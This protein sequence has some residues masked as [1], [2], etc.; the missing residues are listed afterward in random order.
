M[1]KML[2]LTIKHE[3]NCNK[4][5]KTIGLDFEHGSKYCIR[6]KVKKRA[7]TQTRL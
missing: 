4:R 1:R 5:K 2:K 7:H 6:L 3:R